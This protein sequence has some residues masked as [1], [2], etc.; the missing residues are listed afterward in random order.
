MGCETRSIVWTQTGGNRHRVVISD[1]AAAWR[2]YLTLGNSLA[3]QRR[4]SAL[5]AQAQAQAAA[6]GQVG[7][8]IF[9]GIFGGLF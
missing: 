7:G 2:Q 1:V 4:W 3:M 9:A 5:Q 8:S 6:P